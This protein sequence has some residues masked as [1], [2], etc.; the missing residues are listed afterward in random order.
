MS[1][2][3]PISA[4]QS[5]NSSDSKSVAKTCPVSGENVAI[6]PVRYAIDDMDEKGNQLNPFPEKGNWQG[7]FKLKHAKYTM[8]RLRDGWLYVYDEDA[9]TFHEYQVQGANLIKYD[10]GSDEST[11]EASERGTAGDSKVYLSYP[12]KHTLFLGFSYHRWTWRVCEHMRSESADRK[13]WMRK[14]DLNDYCHSDSLYNHHAGYYEGLADAV[15]DIVNDGESLSDDCFIDTCAPFKINEETTKESASANKND[16]ITGA[17]ENYPLIKVKSYAQL[18]EYQ[19]PEKTSGLFIA[20]DDKMADMCDVFIKLGDAWVKQEAILG[21]EVKRHKI[22][23]AELTRSI[24]TVQIPVDQL[25]D[26]HLENPELVL[27][28][29]QQINEF[30]EYYE[31]LSSVSNVVATKPGGDIL[32]NKINAD[33]Y[34][35]WTSFKSSFEKRTLFEITPEME[36]LHKQL[37]QA[38][39][40]NQYKSDELYKFLKEF[41]K[42]IKGNPEKVTSFYFDVTSIVKQLKMDPLVVGIDNQ[43]VGDQTYFLNIASQMVVLLVNSANSKE[44]F[45]ELM[46]IFNFDS[47]DTLLPLAIYGCNYDFWHA[48][49]KEDPFSLLN[50]PSFSLSNQSDWITALT[51]LGEW[52]TL[53]GDARV[54]QKEWYQSLIFPVRNTVDAVMDIYK[55]PAVKYI[56]AIMENLSNFKYEMTRTGIKA[57]KSFGNLTR[58]MSYHILIG[59]YNLQP[60]YNIETPKN[61]EVYNNKLLNARKRIAQL[62]KNNGSRELIKTL[63]KN[64]GKQGSL[65]P[66]VIE[67]ENSEYRSIL[68]NIRGALAEGKTE[69]NTTY[70]KLGGL[71]SFLAMLNAFNLAVVSGNYYSK[72]NENEWFDAA[73]RE[74]LSTWAWAAN[75]VSDIVRDKTWQTVLQKGLLE[76]TLKKSA[77]SKVFGAR[78]LAKRLVMTTMVFG[79][80]GIIAAVLE[81]SCS[82]VNIIDSSYTVFERL[83]YGL[84]VLGLAIQT[85]G[86]L[87]QVGAI[88]LGMELG[89]MMST[90]AI[91]TLW[92]GG[93]LYLVAAAVIYIFGLSDLAR[94]LRTSTWGIE[95]EIDMNTL[96]DENKLNRKFVDE[97]KSLEYLINKPT[98]KAVLSE[99]KTEDKYPITK[100]VWQFTLILPAYMKKKIFGLG[101]YIKKAPEAKIKSR[102]EMR[103]EWQRHGFENFETKMIQVNENG[104][105]SKDKD[106]HLSQYT[107]EMPYSNTDSIQFLIKLPGSM[108][109]NNKLSFF[110][111]TEHINDNEL[112]IKRTDLVDNPPEFAKAIEVK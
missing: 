88:S 58:F 85:A 68:D 73:D 51:R 101:T 59:A 52:N 99:K 89:A 65:A 22:Q 25:G 44:Q 87:S 26:H 54:V 32:S 10:W 92:I 93:V 64:L 3:N 17:L 72:N 100:K 66:N 69:L 18:K 78:I 33:Q 84:K 97:I 80:V 60:T 102:E 4:A 106:T 30:Y 53:N 47:P 1:S 38:K 43:Y 70:E 91:T 49:D 103:Y 77:K 11:K 15:A 75:A 12:A 71:G 105:W 111:S 14:L 98:I 2:D 36:G 62:K 41:Y 94:W 56:N 81:I 95:S 61:L 28:A 50:A 108:M 48:V 109:I 8:R 110:A 16:P 20:L 83:G 35:K 107:F 21:D 7:P 46:K 63:E 34:E 31:S 74:L 37:V 76:T 42:E 90:F 79:V 29:E 55:S 104:K 5:S 86:F 39:L 27:E 112:D 57:T 9:E 6:V 23:M 24:A 13:K 82:L 45:S 19:L 67:L 96:E 40:Y